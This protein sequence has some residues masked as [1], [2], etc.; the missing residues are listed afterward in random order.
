MPA[1]KGSLHARYAGMLHEHALR[2][3]AAA[4]RARHRINCGFW[5]HLILLSSSY[6]VHVAAGGQAKRCNIGI[7]L[8]ADPRI[9]FLDEP[10]SGLDSYTSQEACMTPELHALIVL[11]LT[12]K[13]IAICVQV[14]I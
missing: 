6:I 7:A 8:M 13:R 2:W 12:C 5:F 4:L 11:W 10:T 14:W 3:H 1:R 9:L